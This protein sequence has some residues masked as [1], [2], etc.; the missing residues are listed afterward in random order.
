[1]DIRKRIKEQGFTLGQVAEKMAKPDGT[2]GLPQASLSQI[3]IN[4][5]PSYKKLKEIATIIGISVSAL[6]RDDDEGCVHGSNLVCPHCGKPLVAEI[7]FKAT[8]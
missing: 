4:G 6:V 5:N 8:E 1:M 7:S 3:I 2:I